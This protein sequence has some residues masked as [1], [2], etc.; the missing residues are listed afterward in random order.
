MVLATLL[1]LPLRPFIEPANLVMLYLL[2]VVVAAIRLGRRP[3][4]L[5]SFLSV[6]AFNLFFVPPY[7]T[8]EV[9]SAEYLLTF[10]GLFIVGLVIST[11]A[12]QARDQARAAQRRAAQTA[13]LYEL[14]HDL[15]TAGELETIARIVGS[16]IGQLLDTQAVILLPKQKKLEA[17]YISNG[18]MMDENEQ[19]VAVWVFQHSQAAG[20]GT[21]TLAGVKNSYLPL[22]T[23]QSVVGVL[24]IHLD[25]PGDQLTPEQGRLLESFAN[26]AAQ[27][28]RR[29]QLAREASQAQLLRETEKLQTTLLNSISHDLRT[30]LASITGALSSLRDDAAFLDN[31]ARDILVSTAWEQADRLNTLVGNLLDMTR[32]ESGGMQLRLESCDVQDVIGVALEQL[33]S[34]LDGRSINVETPDD[35]PLVRM[36]FV[37]MAQVLVNLLDNALKYSPLRKAITIRVYITGSELLIE[38]MDQGMGIPEEELSRVFQKFYRG[39]QT[40]SA[41][42][43]GLGLSISKGIVEAH[44]GRIWAKNRAEGGAIFT[45]ALPLAGQKAIQEAVK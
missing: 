41:G 2:A 31:A 18:F 10:A 39:Q 15:A 23:A 7:Y 12:A 6:M 22:K 26:Q 28:I 42:G 4:I 37:L 20:R 17:Y 43:S 38:V 13:A 24:G 3:A 35:L 16:H 19:A 14:S 34:R 5:A 45:V 9:A 30:P 33:A 36:D 40:N 32:L 27:A 1:G 8:Y 25:E 29:V 11:L 21:D 44:N